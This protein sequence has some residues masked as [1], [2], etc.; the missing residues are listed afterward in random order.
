MMP[1]ETQLD[2]AHRQHGDQ[3]RGVARRVDAE[4]QHPGDDEE[5]VEHGDGRDHQPAVERGP[6]RH[7]REAHHAVEREVPEPPEIELARARR[8]L[9]PL[10]GH[11]DR[12]EA[13]PG[14]QALHEAVA[15]GKLAQHL[16]RAPVDQAE[17]ADIGRDAHRRHA[18]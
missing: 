4:D 11:A 14:E 12:V 13:D 2:R 18:C 9:R 7:G 10:V 8:A 1:I 6:Q 5:G 3:Q 15:L 16:D 17:V